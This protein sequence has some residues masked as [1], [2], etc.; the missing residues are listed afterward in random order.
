MY[1]DEDPSEKP[2]RAIEEVVEVVFQVIGK[3]VP[4]DHAW[5]LAESLKAALPWIA[6]DDRV[7]VHGLQ[8]AASGN[9]WMSPTDA[10]EGL[11][12]LSRRS[13]L[14]LRVPR[15]RSFRWVRL[16]LKTLCL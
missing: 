5:S 9:G 13:R 15:A 2:V 4:V 8:G 12:Y 1:W 10:G 7:G 6:E 14:V 16:R 11:V 3:T